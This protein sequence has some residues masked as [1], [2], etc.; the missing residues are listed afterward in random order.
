MFEHSHAVFLL[1]FLAFLFVLSVNYTV[2]RCQCAN[3]HTLHG[4]FVQNFQT[5]KKLPTN[6]PVRAASGELR[7]A[8]FS[9]SA[10]QCTCFFRVS[11]TLSA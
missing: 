6:C 7:Y 10:G 5:N 11:I 4:S 8:L 1:S 2:R 3:F 9:C